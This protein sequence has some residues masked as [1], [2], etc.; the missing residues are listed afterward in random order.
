MTIRLCTVF[1]DELISSA[2]GLFYL[3]M[4]WEYKSGSFLVLA[5]G[6]RG[7]DMVSSDKQR[8]AL[9][10]TPA[11]YDLSTT[12]SAWLRAQHTFADDFLTNGWEAHGGSLEGL[13]LKHETAQVNAA[14]TALRST[15]PIPAEVRGELMRTDMHRLAELE[16]AWINSYQGQR[17]AMRLA[18]RAFFT[19]TAFAEIKRALRLG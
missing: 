2:Q 1:I 7:A 18:L 6:Q 10:G 17:H 15:M 9:K 3:S 4:R 5:S 11:V 8:A 12:W 13:L 14:A 16:Q 19:K